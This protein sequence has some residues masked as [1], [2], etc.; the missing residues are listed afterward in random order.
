M[1]RITENQFNI[2]YQ[3]YAKELFNIAYGYTRNKEDTLD[4]VQTVYVKLLQSNRSFRTN[5][6]IHFYLIR[7]TINESIN[8]IK[9]SY[10]KKVIK[11]TDFIMNLS[12]RQ[13][14]NSLEMI[15]YALDILSEKYQTVIVLH[16]YDRMKIKDISNVLKISE[17]AVKKR[18][19]RA[20]KLMKEWI[21]RK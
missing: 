11:N 3:E 2:V 18:L 21:E 10:Q 7:I 13:E 15:T 8:W 6:D 12:D 14:E 17:T 4:I 16:Y 5:D 19:E 1:I 9:S 20:R